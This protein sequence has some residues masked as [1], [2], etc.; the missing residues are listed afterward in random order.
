MMTLR[1]AMAMVMAAAVLCP[2]VQAEILVDQSY[3]ELNY[4]NYMGAH[5]TRD[6]GQSFVPTA[7]NITSVELYLVRYEM[8]EPGG[9]DFDVKIYTTDPCNGWPIGAPLGTASMNTYD[10]PDANTGGTWDWYNFDFGSVSVT[11]GQQ[12]ALMVEIAD[13]APTGN[14]RVAADETGLYAGGNEI[15]TADP[16][17]QRTEWD[18]MFKTYSWM[19]VV[20][21]DTYLPP[22]DNY[23]GAHA[24]RDVG[25]SFRATSNRLERIDLYLQRYKMYEVG[26]RDFEVKVYETDPC[27][28]WPTGPP[29]A[30]AMRNTYDIMDSQEGGNFA[31]YDFTFAPISLIPVFL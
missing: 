28:G 31:W 18:M 7:D 12:Y 3:D 22:Y 16:C 30:T 17:M 5:A 27:N 4:S 21:T 19:P 1:M 23:M 11:P 29:L 25:Q 8:Y 10:I 24:T 9:R 20:L 14:I 2:M 15:Q 13:D 26:G 6:V